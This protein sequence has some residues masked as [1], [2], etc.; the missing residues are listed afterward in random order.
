MYGLI[1]NIMVNIKW[2]PESFLV[3]DMVRSRSRKTTRGADPDK[4]KLASIDVREHN[5]SVRKAAEAHG[6]PKTSL[7]RYMSSSS[8]AKRHWSSYGHVADAQ[9]VFSLQQETTL[10]DHIKTLDN[11]F[12]GLSAQQ[13]RELA[14]RYASANEANTPPSWNRNE[15]AGEQHTFS[16]S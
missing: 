8:P 3:A 15:I 14:Y 11:L 12:H 2:T 1:I 9:R 10:A 6:I 7:Q 5:V 13:C 4:L 16:F